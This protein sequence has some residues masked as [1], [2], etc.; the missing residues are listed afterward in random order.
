MCPCP[1]GLC[2]CLVVIQ[3][4][5]Q[6]RILF[7]IFLVILLQRSRTISVKALPADQSRTGSV[8]F[9][10]SAVLPGAT[11]RNLSSSSGFL[12]HLCSY[13]LQKKKKR[14][15]GTLPSTTW[16]VDPRAASPGQPAQLTHQ[17]T[18]PVKR[19]TTFGPV[20]ASEVV[21]PQTGQNRLSRCSSVSASGDGTA[22]VHRSMRREL[23]RKVESG[24]GGRGGFTRR[25]KVANVKRSR[26]S[27]PQAAI[28][29]SVENKAAAN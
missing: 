27:G 3:G 1:V 13:D 16:C 2:P 29:V 23:A 24:G 14:Q 5:S 20:S 28:L 18:P 26:F 11:R 15:T 12:M 22:R 7:S 25:E 6:T 8:R 21:P 4:S 9:E 19:W 10:H 17:Q